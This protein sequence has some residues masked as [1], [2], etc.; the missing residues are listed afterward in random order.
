MSAQQKRVA[1]PARSGFRISGTLVDA[2]SGQ[3]LAHGRV[4]IA[5]VTQRNSF[6]TVI[7]REDGRF[8][9]SSLA[10][11]KYTL[12][13]QARGHLLQSFNQHDHFASSIAVGPKK[14]STNLLFRLSPESAIFGVVSDEAGE[15]VRNAEVML[16]F[17]GL[18][19]GAETTRP[20]GRATTDDEGTYHFGHLA[21]GRYL[22]AVSAKPWY[23]RYLSARAGTTG[24]VNSAAGAMG[25][26]ARNTVDAPGVAGS[27]NQQGNPQLNVAYPITFYS[28]ATDAAAATPIVLGV[29]D[30]FEADINLQPVPALHVRVQTGRGDSQP[31]KFFVL[32]RRVLDGPP[33]QIPTEI[34]EEGQGVQ[35]IVGIPAGHYTVKAYIQGKGGPGEWAPSH[36]IDISDQGEIDQD[37]GGSYVPISA[38]LQFDSGTPARQPWLRLVNQQSRQVFAQPLNSNGKVT[39]KQ[40]VPA[41]SYEVAIVNSP[42]AYLKSI[43][44]AGAEVS[45]RTI[46]VRPGSPVRLT[47][48]AARGEGEITG[49]ALRDGKPLAG[50]MI[51]LVPADPAHNQ[52]LFRR[53]QSDSDGTFTLSQVVPGAYTVV[54]IENGWKLEWMKPE[55][56]K[57]Y[58]PGGTPVQAQPKGKY[59]VKVAVQ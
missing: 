16:Y 29:G 12:A 19:A 20:R 2:V 48:H 23:A 1:T 32:E 52:V 24:F 58:L 35:E 40:G 26:T 36:E 13:A 25:L 38:T 21:P 9:F 39:F 43:S 37:Q 17:T 50:A 44:A 33:I 7:T 6:T 15:P 10:P 30:K 41:G 59:N 47:I 31:G 42:G 18:S 46:E 49:T 56:L 27:G 8:L 45:G 11:G 55:V 5:P 28:G 34:R 22:V 3:P 4:A 14:S 51:V 57:N 54:A 53:D